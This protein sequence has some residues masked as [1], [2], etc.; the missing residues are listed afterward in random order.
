MS[1]H[2]AT[3]NDGFKM[4][5]VKVGEGP[6]LMVMVHGVPEFWYG[7]YPLLQKYIN[8][9]EYTVIAPDMRGYNLTDK[10]GE[11]KDYQVKNMV[12][13]LNV[14]VKTLGFEKFTLVGHDWGGIVCWWFA[15]VNPDFLEKFIIINS[16]HPLIFVREMRENPA[17]QAGNTYTQMF[18]AKGS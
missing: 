8:S 13:Y 17:Q 16:P 4:H 10:P 1:S 18:R 12:D 3:I 9:K 2:F 7:Y 5:Y 11:V 6:K 14:L 15:M